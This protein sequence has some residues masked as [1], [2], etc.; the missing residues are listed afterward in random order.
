MKTN[1]RGRLFDSASQKYEKGHSNFFGSSGL[2]A[3]FLLRILS[4]T[5]EPDEQLRPCSA[6]DGVY[7][8][9]PL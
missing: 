9:E 7:D 3:P 5:N 8:G 2:R 6:F 1:F 4:V